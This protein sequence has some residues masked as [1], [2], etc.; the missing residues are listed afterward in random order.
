MGCINELQCDIDIAVVIVANLC[1]HK[2]W[3]FITN[4][5]LSKL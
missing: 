4:G 2:A 5:V 3:M 1:N